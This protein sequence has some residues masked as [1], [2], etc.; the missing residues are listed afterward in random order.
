[1]G[2]LVTLGINKLFFINFALI[3]EKSWK[4]HPH[5]LQETIIFFR[6]IDG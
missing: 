6:I 3:A 5:I 4:I 1:M 2:F